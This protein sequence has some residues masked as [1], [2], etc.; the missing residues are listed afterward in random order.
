LPAGVRL[1]KAY[2]DPWGL[3]SDGLVRG[4]Q[5]LEGGREDCALHQ[6]ERFELET[7]AG[8]QP[9]L[10]VGARMPPPDHGAPDHMGGE[11]QRPEW[12]WEVKLTAGIETQ[13]FRGPGRFFGVNI[14]SSIRCGR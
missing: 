3:S 5:V 7:T 2:A 8:D 1:E 11:G 6:G 9:R 12:W 10:A 4:C 13:E 14:D